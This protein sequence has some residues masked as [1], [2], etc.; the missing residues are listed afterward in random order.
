MG[1]IVPVICTVTVPGKDPVVQGFWNL[2]DFD[3]PL[4]RII[5]TNKRVTVEK[6]NGTVV[7]YEMKT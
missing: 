3:I 7:V 4:G 6:T 1:V 2:T 5:G